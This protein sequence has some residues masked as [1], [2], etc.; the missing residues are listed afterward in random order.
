MV[1]EATLL[2]F[3]WQSVIT[4]HMNAVLVLEIDYLHLQY[5]L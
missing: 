4:N 2:V 3:K 5:L 1:A